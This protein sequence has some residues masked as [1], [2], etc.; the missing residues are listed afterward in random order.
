MA[1]SLFNIEGDDDTHAVL[2]NGKVSVCGRAVYFPLGST[3][4]P[5]CPEC[6][7]ALKAEDTR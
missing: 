1:H 4:Q 2:D 6:I 7:N 3:D 5:T